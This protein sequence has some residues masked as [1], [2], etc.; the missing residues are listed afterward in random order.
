MKKSLIWLEN[1]VIFVTGWTSGIWKAVVLQAALNGAKVAF[2]WRRSPEWTAVIQE[3]RGMW[4]SEQNIM[5]FQCDVTNFTVLEAVVKNVI[6]KRGGIDWLFCCAW[7]HIVW[8]ILNT[9]LD[10]RNDLWNVNVTSMFMTMKFILP[11]MIDRQWGNIVLMWSD[12]SFIWKRESSIYGATKAA[13]WQLTKS[14]ALDY[15]EYWIRINGVC[16]GTI[17]TALATR[18]ADNFAKEL[19]DGD[20]Q[21]AKHDFE[22]AQAI[23]RLWTSEEVAELVNFLL[24][25]QAAYMTG[26][27]VSIDWWYTAA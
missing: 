22:Q 13:I 26:T 24:S 21:K 11:N 10:Q 19:F 27:L 4:I 14:T 17:D 25:D 3:A 23:K 7:N 2:V 16:P 18:A 12:Q 6:S 1:R 20:I 15:A 5:F 8:D 9:S